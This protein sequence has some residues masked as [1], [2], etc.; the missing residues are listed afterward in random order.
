MGTDKET[1]AALRADLA[2]AR[3]ALKEI[4]EGAA[5]LRQEDDGDLVRDG[6]VTDDD[7]RQAQAML[8]LSALA[9]CGVESLALGLA[10]ARLAGRESMQVE[11]DEARARA[12]PSTGAA[13]A[14]ADLADARLRDERVTDANVRHDLAE[15]LRLSG[16]A[17][18][19]PK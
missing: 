16:A 19:V 3:A 7:I 12:A 4:A 5:R 1:I 2:E 17:G 14:I 13:Q 18:T 10:G 9:P 15:I 11:R 8:A 6:I